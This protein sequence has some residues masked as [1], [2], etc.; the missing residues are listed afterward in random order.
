M[1]SNVNTFGVHGR[2]GNDPRE[3][4]GENS[5]VVS[6]RM[7]T[8]VDCRNKDGR[9]EHQLWFNLLFF[10]SLGELMMKYGKSG[11]QIFVTGAIQAS[12]YK[13]K[14]GNDCENMEILVKSFYVLPEAKP[15]SQGEDEIPLVLFE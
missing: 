7:A 9:C 6:A 3:Y 5:T 13:D 2:L 15:Q 10:G 8:T 1:F 14:E 12:L 11:K 4:K